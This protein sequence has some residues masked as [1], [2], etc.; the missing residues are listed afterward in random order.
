MKERK[1][2]KKGASLHSERVKVVVV[3]EY[4]TIQE[5]AKQ[6]K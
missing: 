5:K 6:G 4:K 1:K 2:K 3:N